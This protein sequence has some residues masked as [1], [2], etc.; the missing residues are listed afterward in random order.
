MTIMQKTEKYYG[1]FNLFLLRGY[2]PRV[3]RKSRTSLIPKK[4]ECIEPGDYRPISVAS[5]VRR[6][7]HSALGKR[8]TL[9]VSLS[10]RQKGFRPV[11]GTAENIWL[12]NALLDQSRAK[13]RPIQVAFLDVAKA[14]DSVS[15]QS[16]LLACERIGLPRL[17]TDY[18][19]AVY[20]DSKTIICNQDATRIKRGILQGDLHTQRR[21]SSLLQPS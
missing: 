10:N 8:L 20:A 9:E 14:F 17:L 21:S 16:L 6:L 3:L 11:D 1:W 18:I 15:H 12:V 13:K 4:S 5:L 19:A 2:L 7:F